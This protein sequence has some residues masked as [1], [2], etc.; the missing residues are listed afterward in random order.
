MAAPNTNYA[1]K[2]I[3]DWGWVWETSSNGWYSNEQIA[4][5]GAIASAQYLRD[6]LGELQQ[7][8]HDIRMLGAEGLHDLIRLE[9]RRVRKAERARRTR[10]AK[11]RAATI[12]SKKAG[13]V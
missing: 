4:A 10:A 11:R 6:V 5:I 13:S 12:A 3:C 9:A 8:K 1:P 7:I 2:Q